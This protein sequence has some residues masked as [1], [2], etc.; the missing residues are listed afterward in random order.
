MYTDLQNYFT[1][2]FLRK[3]CTHISYR[4]FTSL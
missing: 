2:R 4:F 3:F 1:D